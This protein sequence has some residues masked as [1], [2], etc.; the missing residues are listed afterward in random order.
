MSGGRSGGSG[1]G[2]AQWPQVALSGLR[3]EV[4]DDASFG[5][6]VLW[7]GKQVVVFGFV[8]LKLGGLE[9]LGS[10]NGDLGRC[11]DAV[12]GRADTR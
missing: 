11:V 5:A 8:F 3:S 9:F 2:G 1:R 10:L 4:N 7:R 12:G 6:E